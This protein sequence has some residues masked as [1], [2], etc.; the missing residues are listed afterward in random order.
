MLNVS[1]SHTV[2]VTGGHHLG[3]FGRRCVG[4]AGQDSWVAVVGVSHEQPDCFVWGIISD[5]DLLRTGLRNGEQPSARAL[6]VEPVVVV[7]PS[8]PLREAGEQMLAH[9]VS[10]LIV[11]DSDSKRPV[12]VLSTLDVAGVL[13]WGEA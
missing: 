6:A 11:A 5:L 2:D 10:H 13:A 4:L 1:T 9:G 8:T 7:D 12:G 3:D